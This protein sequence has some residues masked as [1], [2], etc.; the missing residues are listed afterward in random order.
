[1]V[2]AYSHH[3]DPVFYGFLKTGVIWFPIRLS[4]IPQHCSLDPTLHPPIRNYKYLMIFLQKPSNLIEDPSLLPPHPHFLQPM[5]STSNSLL[6]LYASVT[7]VLITTHLINPQPSERLLASVNTTS[8]FNWHL[9][10]W[11]IELHLVYPAQILFSL[12]KKKKAVS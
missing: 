4:Q 3:P 11:F 2:S 9:L 10:N 5:K 7:A 12:K 1:M 8:F 6:T